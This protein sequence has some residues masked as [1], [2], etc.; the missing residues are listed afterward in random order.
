MLYILEVGLAGLGRLAMG[1]MLKKSI[2]GD[3]LGLIDIGEH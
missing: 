2:G 3:D 1:S